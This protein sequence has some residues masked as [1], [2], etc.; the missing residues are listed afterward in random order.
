MGSDASVAS[1]KI[2]EPLYLRDKYG[3]VHKWDKFSGE[4]SRSWVTGPERARDKHS[5][6]DYAVVGKHEYN[7]Q[8]WADRNRYNIR[9][10][11]NVCDA[12][13]LRKIAELLGY[14]EATD[15]K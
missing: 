9:G 7:E 11:F 15:A 14:R 1:P 13:T 2:G 8:L 12:P 5:K 3:Q 10:Y 6:K 4:T